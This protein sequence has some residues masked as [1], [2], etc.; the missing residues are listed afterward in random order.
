VT[1]LN[2]PEGTA[3]VRLHESHYSAR[4][5]VLAWSSIDFDDTVVQLEIFRGQ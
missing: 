5:D 3:F 4:A 1:A 2:L